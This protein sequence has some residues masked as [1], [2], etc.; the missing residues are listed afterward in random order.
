MVGCDFIE[1][2]VVYFK[3]VFALKEDF[4]LGL[5]LLRATIFFLIIKEDCT[6]VGKGEGLRKVGDFDS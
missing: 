3:E 4:T 2:F 1:S 5:D 6:I